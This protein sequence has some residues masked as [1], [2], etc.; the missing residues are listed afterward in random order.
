MIAAARQAAY[1]VLRAVTSGRADLPAAL[2]RVRGRLDDE[3]DRALAGE[4]ATGT[5]RWM[6]TFDHVIAQYTGRLPAKL[7]PEILDILRLTAFQILHL[8]RVPASAAVNDAV[9][10]ARKAG[11]KSAAGLVNAVLRRLSRER[12]KLPLPARPESPNASRTAAVAYL[13]ITLSH[14]AW[15]VERWLDRFGFEAAEAWAR[16]NNEPAPLTLR[17]NLLRGPR[18]ALAEDLRAAGVETEPTRFAP[19]GLVV[20]SGNP[21]LTPLAGTGRFVVQDEASQ[22]VA[23]LMGA[24]PGERI[25]DACASPGGKTTA[26]AAAMGN[27]GCIVA[28]DVRERRVALLAR[29]VAEAGATVARVVQANAAVPLPFTP[30]FD[31]ALL[32]APCSGLGTIR[33]D[34]EIRWRRQPGEL[35]RL[36]TAQAAM[37][38]EV[39]RTVR[40]GGRILYA[41]CSSEVDENEDV[42]ARVV[43]SEPHLA[44]APE[45]IPPELARFRTE[46]G[47]FRTLPFRD[48]LEAFFGAILV[49]TR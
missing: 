10:L 36:G 28:A 30:I 27:R 32:D 5:L 29:T 48:G 12:G 46:Y 8:D 38:R 4:I 47:C 13:S 40:P 31:A 44:L 6:G 19:H 43:A 1:D 34:P 14:P 20:K 11:K 24:Q 22:L 16:F 2:A 35:E 25:L 26:M 7:D 9:N 17:A 45:R 41:T 42:V 3:R 18:D 49:R 33:R 21:L 37:L 39:A 15:L 23:V